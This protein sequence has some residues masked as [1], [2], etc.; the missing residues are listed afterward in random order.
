MARDAHLR[1]VFDLLDEPAEIADPVAVAIVKRLD[2]D[3]VNDGVLE[4]RRGVHRL[5]NGSVRSAAC[6]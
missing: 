5:N 2:V 3:F 1:K 4:P 6:I